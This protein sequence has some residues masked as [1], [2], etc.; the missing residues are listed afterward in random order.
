LRHR[1]GS[2]KA[3]GGM[4]RSENAPFVSDAL[5]RA[6]AQAAGCRCRSRGCG[7][8]QGP[9]GPLRN[10]CVAAGRDARS[11]WRGMLKRRMLMCGKAAIR[12]TPV[13][14]CGRGVP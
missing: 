12:E 4:V 11:A 2:G 5:T 10:R 7:I 6:A 8:R 9:S 14:A 3:T 1:R 13:E